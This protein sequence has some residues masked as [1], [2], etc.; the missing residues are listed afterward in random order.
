[1]PNVS[2]LLMKGAILVLEPNTG[3]PLYTINL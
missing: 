3:I 2:P 1:M